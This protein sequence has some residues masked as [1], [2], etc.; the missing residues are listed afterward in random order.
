MSEVTRTHIPARLDR[1]PW[2]R[3]HWLIVTGLGITWVLDGLE[4]TLAGTIGGVIKASL[5]MSDAQV[6][7]SATFC[8]RGAVL[9]AFFFGWLADRLGRKKLF[10]V[11]L[12]VYLL[13]TAAT[14][15]SWNFASYSVFRF[16]T[17]FGIR[18]AYAAIHSPT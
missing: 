4:V 1:L 3:W 12:A 11:P 17:G 5:H 16:F 7:D 15:F 14:A 18:G 8:L 13:A 9:G 10:M 2:S 6:C